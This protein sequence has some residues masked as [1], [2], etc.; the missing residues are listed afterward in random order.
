MKTRRGAC[1]SCHAAPGEGPEVQ[2]RKRRRT[3]AEASP[4]AAE[5]P[6]VRLG[7][8]DM[9]EDLPDDLVVSILRDVAASAGSPADLAGA[10]LTYVRPVYR[11]CLLVPGAWICNLDVCSR[12]CAGARDSGS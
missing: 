7:G 12:V 6:G 11:A 5:A 10:M 1:Y 2:R 8:R 3:A 9:F 4:A